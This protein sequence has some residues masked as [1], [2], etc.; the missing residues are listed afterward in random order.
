MGSEM[1]SDFWFG[2]FTGFGISG[3]IASY[4]FIRW[5]EKHY[6]LSHRSF[7]YH[8]TKGDH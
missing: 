4:V 6:G 8:P 3:C 7:G 2:L 1:L 5:L